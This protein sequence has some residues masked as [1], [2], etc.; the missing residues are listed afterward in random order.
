[1]KLLTTEQQEQAVELIELSLNLE[2]LYDRNIYIR[3]AKAFLQSLK[4]KVYVC[5]I[6]EDGLMF[7]L[8][9]DNLFD[10]DFELAKYFHEFDEARSVLDSIEKYE[11]NKYFI[12]T[13]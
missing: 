6:D 10:M 2:T 13:E 7:Y 8:R 11:D 1:M 9:E 12:L 5:N 4:P 3:S